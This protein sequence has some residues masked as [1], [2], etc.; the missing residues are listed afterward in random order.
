MAP[1]IENDPEQKDRPNRPETALVW[2]SDEYRQAFL[3][4]FTKY[5]EQETKKSGTPRNQQLVANIRAIR[6]TVLD[7]LWKSAGA[8]PK[9][10]RRWWE[11][12]L[13]RETNDVSDLLRQYVDALGLNVSQRVCDSRIAPSPG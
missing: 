6:T 8:P 7:D 10:G 12:R 4:I 1:A 11:L 13:R 2:V 3:E 5:L 9:Q